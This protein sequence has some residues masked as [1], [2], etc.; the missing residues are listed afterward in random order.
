VKDALRRKFSSVYA[1]SPL[2]ATDCILCSVDGRN[3]PKTSAGAENRRWTCGDDMTDPGP[4]KLLL[5][6][7]TMPEYGST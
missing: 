2:V 5:P 1:L 7:S 6:L 4:Y 3:S